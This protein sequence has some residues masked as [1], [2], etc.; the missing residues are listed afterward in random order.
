MTWL[1]W[2]TRP[3]GFHHDTRGPDWIKPLK[4]TLQTGSNSQKSTL[5]AITGLQEEPAFP[6]RTTALTSWL[7]WNYTQAICVAFLTMHAYPQ[8]V[9]ER[10]VPSSVGLYYKPN[11]CWTEAPHRVAFNIAE[12]NAKSIQLRDTRRRVQF[13]TNRCSR[14][15][16]RVMWRRHD[17]LFDSRASNTSTAESAHSPTNTSAKETTSC[18]SRSFK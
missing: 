5:S 14:L 9:P 8:T 18:D 13:F 17:A 12:T 15:P 16:P 4:F 3:E 7:E 1:K 10:R 6:S 2:C 11:K